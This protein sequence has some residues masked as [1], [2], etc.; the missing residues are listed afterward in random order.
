MPKMD[1][2]IYEVMALIADI[3]ADYRHAVNDPLHPQHREAIRAY[4][5]LSE[6]CF[7]ELNRRGSF[8]YAVGKQAPPPP[9]LI[10]RRPGFRPP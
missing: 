3:D 7:I 1:S 10:E 8:D 9:P 5:E 2:H 4:Q 6:F